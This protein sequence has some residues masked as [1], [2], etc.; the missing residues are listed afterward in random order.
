MV[1]SSL[2]YRI[3]LSMKGFSGLLKAVCVAASQFAWI[4]SSVLWTMFGS[5][6]RLVSILVSPPCCTI[7][8][9]FLL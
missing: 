2:L 6:P 5:S 3:D 8:E 4:S 7:C 9:D 1:F